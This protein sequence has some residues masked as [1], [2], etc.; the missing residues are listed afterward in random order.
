[1]E[2]WKAGKES[3]SKMVCLKYVI[4]NKKGARDDL[5]MLVALFHDKLDSA[6]FHSPGEGDS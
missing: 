3:C 6:M 2:D 4:T 1:M 5:D